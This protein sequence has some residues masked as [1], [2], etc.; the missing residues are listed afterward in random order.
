[1][2]VFRVVFL[3]VLVQVVTVHQHY[4]LVSPARLI[5]DAKHEF[6]GAICEGDVLASPRHHFISFGY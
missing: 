5:H 3:R 1:M 2:W 4:P 6:R